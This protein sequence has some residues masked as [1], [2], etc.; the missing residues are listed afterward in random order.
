MPAKIKQSSFID[1]V[2]S[3]KGITLLII[4][5]LVLSV[6]TYFYS[7]RGPQ[8][9][10]GSKI[11][12]KPTP[13]PY[14]LPQEAQTYPFGYGSAIKGPKPSQI[15]ISPYDPKKGVKQTFTVKIKYEK[16][17]TYAAIT[18]GTD[19]KEQTYNLSR[20]SGTEPGEST[21][22][23]TIVTDDTHYYK[24]TVAI[25]FRSGEEK[26]SIIPKLTLRAY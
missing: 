10:R 24:Y 2:L 23:T 20:I 12:A 1:D 9:F 4:T 25:D 16:P 14:P 21:W 8:V 19:T 11:T 6:G 5:L 7:R 17:I 18:L 22:E 13:T 15:T 3:P 26:T